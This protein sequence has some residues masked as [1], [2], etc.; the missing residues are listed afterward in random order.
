MRLALVGPLPPP[1]GGMANQT[2]QLAGL[3]KAGGVDVALARTNE[4]YRPAWVQSIRGVRAAFRLAPYVLRLAS[5]AK[6]CDVAHV[7]ANSGWAWHLF[8][9]P[10]VRLMSR[11]SVPVIVNYRGGLAREFLR[12]S[13]RSVRRTLRRADAVVVPTRFLQQ[14]FG[15]FGI[16]TRII[17]NIVDLD[18]FRPAQQVPQGPIHIVIARNLEHIYGIDIA[19]RAVAILRARTADVRV[20]IAG[21]GP[22][23]QSLERLAAE[24]GLASCVRFTGSLDP[25]GIAAL[26]REA[27]IALNPS[28]ADNA[29][30]SLLEAAACGLPIVSTNVG[31]IPYLVEHMRTAWLVPPEDPHAMAEG[32]SRVL[33]DSSLREALRTNGLALARSCSWSEIGRQWIDLYRA[34]CR[35]GPTRAIPVGVD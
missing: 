19:I 23:R 30:N 18:L 15:E 21:E 16:E 27:H 12:R 3:L 20:S 26:Y 33:N 11:R 8:A 29:P 25:T 32:I 35:T 1:A 4:P 5:L 31:G 10:A 14:V 9:A 2:R 13:G 34:V 17:P 7:M 6:A 28:R 22:Q 24:E